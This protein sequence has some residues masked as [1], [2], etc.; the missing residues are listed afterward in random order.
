MQ[1]YVMAR[2]RLLVCINIF[3]FSALSFPRGHFILALHTQDNKYHQY[4]F[5]YKGYSSRSEFAPRGDEGANIL[6]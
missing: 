3:L 6:F 1:G 5:Q 2:H 4:R